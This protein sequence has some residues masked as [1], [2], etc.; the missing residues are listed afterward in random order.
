MARDRLGVV[1]KRMLASS[2][3]RRNV[4]P[5][6]STSSAAEDTEMVRAQNDRSTLTSDFYLCDSTWDHPVATTGPDVF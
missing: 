4:D 2:K 3:R 1:V 6:F 5:S